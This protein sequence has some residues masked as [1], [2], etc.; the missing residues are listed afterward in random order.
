MECF[1]NKV[2]KVYFEKAHE[3]A[4]IPTY[5]NPTDAGMDLYT[6]SDVIINPGETKIISTGLKM[7]MKPGYEAQIRPRSGI[8]SSTKLR[9][10]NSPGTID[11]TYRD[12]VGV[13]IQNTST[14]FYE[15]AKELGIT[16]YVMMYEANMHYAYPVDK[17]DKGFVKNANGAY[18]IPA[19]TRIAQMVIA[20]V[21][22][23]K[24]EE[25]DDVLEVDP[26]NREGG[27]GS[28]GVN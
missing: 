6:V 7:V 8:A 17:K 22:K 11:C 24:I 27:F 13:A 23:V 2:E 10:V 16:E 21:A 4:V 3:D 18:F 25:C 20:K 15:I 5:A 26:S 9:V 28:S 1:C 12:I 14:N 19:G